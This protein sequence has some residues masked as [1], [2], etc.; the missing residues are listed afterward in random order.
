MYVA[1]SFRS[2]VSISDMS[3]VLGS[4]TASNL[5]LGVFGAQLQ[6]LAL[7]GSSPVSTDAIVSL[8]QLNLDSMGNPI[9]T[10]TVFGNAQLNSVPF[11][12]ASVFSLFALRMSSANLWTAPC[13]AQLTPTNTSAP[14][15]VLNAVDDLNGQLV[16]AGI[17]TSPLTG[18]AAC[19]FTGS[20]S[21]PLNAFVTQMSCPAP[22]CTLLVCLLFLC[23]DAHAVLQHRRPCS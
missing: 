14:R 5:Y 1:G 7:V 12:S 3:D 2:R 16:V 4:T 9:V 6:P 20:V 21:S 13:L 17:M 11:G 10:G 8:A 19:S 23:L 18:T 22:I 15:P